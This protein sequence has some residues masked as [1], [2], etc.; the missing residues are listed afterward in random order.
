MKLT[1]KTKKLKALSTANE[2]GVNQT[3]NIGGAAEQQ[4]GPSKC[5]MI[6]QPNATDPS[7]PSICTAV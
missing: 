6:N 2:L 4:T 3:P 7:K 5:T 1:L